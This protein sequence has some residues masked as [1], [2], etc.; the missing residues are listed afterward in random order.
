[1]SLTD[2]E[3]DKY[4]R[5]IMIP[6]FGVEAQEKLK[7]SAALVTR[8]GGL[9]GPTAIWLAAAGIGKLVIAHGGKLT[10]SNLNR[11]ILMRG[12]SVGE[13]RAPQAEETLRRFSP[14]VEL[15]TYAADANADNV[16]DWVGQVDIVCDT[17]PDFRERLL[18]NA[19]CVRQGKPLVDS[20]MNGM[21]AQ[22]SVFH[23]PDTPCLQCLVPEV[24]D[25]WDPM[26]FGVLGALSGA[27]G[28]L[29]ALE[30]VKVL[31]GYG[32]PLKGKLLVFDG[33][34]MSFNKYTINKRPDCP[35]CG[36]AG[37]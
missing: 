2:W 6:D 7:N 9:G 18:L 10:P 19:E 29:T 23:P 8:L 30:V 17:T 25:W 26:G 28:A 24:P 33:E 34:D 3:L 27:L 1:M 15:V 32:E 12:D 37:A 4:R 16:A 22:L 5:Q 11:Q 31:T 20:G 14:D 36:Q 21:E 35:I 13:P